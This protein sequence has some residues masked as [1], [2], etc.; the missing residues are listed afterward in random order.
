MKCNHCGGEMYTRQRFRSEHAVA[1]EL[2]CADCG[3]QRLRSSLR[4][5]SDERGAAGPI[6]R[7]VATTAASFP[8][9]AVAD[10][11]AY[12]AGL[13]EAFHALPRRRSARGH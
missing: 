10:A 12:A 8:R 2:R 4:I 13:D 5:A 6:G 11:D 1:Q 9:R 7:S 3:A